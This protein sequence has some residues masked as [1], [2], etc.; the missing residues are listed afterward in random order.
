MRQVKT[1]R[2]I[3][4]KVK[5]IGLFIVIITVGSGLFLISPTGQQLI[6]KVQSVYH[7]VTQKSHLSLKSVKLEGH[8]RTNV[9]TV[10]NTLDLAPGMPIL[11]VD[12]SDVQM[13]VAALPWVDGVTVERH[14]PDTVYIRITEKN[15]IAVWQNNKRYFPLDETGQ[16]I[17][18]NQ[19]VLS[20]L[21]LVVG[22]D[23]PEHTADLVA[24]LEKYPDIRDITVS[25][26]RVGDRRWNLIL[27]DL[28]NPITVYLPET[29]EDEA[30]A[31]LQ[32]WQEQE[33][34]LDRAFQVIDLRI[35]DRLI[36]RTAADL[37]TDT[38][39]KK[40]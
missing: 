31:R 17:K 5:L 32:K 33:Q 16:P 12:L 38:K 37:D 20:N 25:A 36:V 23:A 2:K 26:V 24:A 21:I 11:Q 27:R 9:K 6:A 10:M 28:K 4:L 15:P 1:K 8:N 18:D 40:K 34:V 22:R 39:D 13:R 3:S 19:T 35:E 7:S 14:L 30:L 29:D